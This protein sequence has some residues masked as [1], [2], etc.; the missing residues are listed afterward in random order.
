MT[1]KLEHIAVSINLAFPISIQDSERHV[2]VLSV[3]RLSVITSLHE[4]QS[5]TLFG[6]HIMLYHT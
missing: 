2:A 5:A 6:Y 3:K 4:W 1:M